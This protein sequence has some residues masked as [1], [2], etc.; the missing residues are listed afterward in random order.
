MNLR[1]SRNL[2]GLFKSKAD[3]A[4]AIRATI[5]ELGEGEFRSFVVGCLSSRKN[6]VTQSSKGIVRSG[7]TSLSENTLTTP[8]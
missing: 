6:S 4:A 1:R 7:Q 5:I 3:D 8:K 2:K